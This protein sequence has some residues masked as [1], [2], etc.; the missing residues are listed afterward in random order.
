VHGHPGRQNTG[1][2]D[3]RHE[4]TGELPVVPRAGEQEADTHDAGEADDDDQGVGH[5][6]AGV[7]AVRVL[8]G[9]RCVESPDREPREDGEQHRER[10][11]GSHDRDG[12]VAHQRDHHAHGDTS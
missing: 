7:V 8:A 12:R 3:D 2:A 5:A 11:P 1:H 10:R 6:V 9:L 4:G